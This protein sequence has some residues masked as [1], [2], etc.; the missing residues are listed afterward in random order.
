M[1]ERNAICEIPWIM[2]TE[3][4]GVQTLDDQLFLIS[5]LE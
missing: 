4:L 2:F 1:Q 3:L 5:S